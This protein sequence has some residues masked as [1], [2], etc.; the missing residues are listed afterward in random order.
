MC[1]VRRR[2]CVVERVG[3]VDGGDGCRQRE[4]TWGSKE[5]RRRVAERAGLALSTREA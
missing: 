1:R 4:G 5:E 2:R 3:V